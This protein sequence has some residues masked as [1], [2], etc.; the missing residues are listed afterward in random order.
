MKND[1][2]RPIRRITF[3]PW[4][5]AL[6][7]SSENL[8]RRARVYLGSTNA[9]TWSDIL[10]NRRRWL[11]GLFI[12]QV[13]ATLFLSAVGI[14]ASVMATTIQS[15]GENGWQVHA[16]VAIAILIIACM[17][18][19][20]NVRLFYFVFVGKRD[21]EAILQRSVHAEKH[22]GNGLRARR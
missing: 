15:S 20:V 2:S 13:F 4:W 8:H 5:G 17:H 18:V 1:R 12:L 6:L 7:Y 11:V 19:P 10:L 14:L 3:M 9:D 21:I 16:F 22:S